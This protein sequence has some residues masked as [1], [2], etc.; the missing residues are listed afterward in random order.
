MTISRKQVLLLVTMTAWMIASIKIIT[1]I[2]LSPLNIHNLYNDNEVTISCDIHPSVTLSVGIPTLRRTSVG[3]QYLWETVRGFVSLS[4]V[5]NFKLELLIFDFTDPIQSGLLSSD[6]KLSDGKYLSSVGK[7]FIKVLVF[8]PGKNRTNHL[9]KNWSP[10]PGIWR[11]INR[12]E[13]K[14]NEDMLHM[15][16]QLRSKACPSQFPNQTAKCGNKH[17]VMLT[18]DDFVPCPRRFSQEIPQ[19]LLS[20]VVSGRNI[21]G[22]RVSSGGSGILIPCTSLENV[23]DSFERMI[24]RGPADSLL[25]FILTYQPLFKYSGLG[26]PI[27]TLHEQKQPYLVYKHSVMQHIGVRRTR[28]GEYPTN[29][30]TN[31]GTYVPGCSSTSLESVGIL[32][33]ETFDLTCLK[34]GSL[35]SPCEKAPAVLTT[36]ISEHYERRYDTKYWHPWITLNT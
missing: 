8:H 14:H 16:R 7:L 5:R 31:F 17:W 6:G 1:Y 15:M 3:F 22:I 4:R 30:P 27:V 2:Y 18:E 33:A 32:I 25:S 9:L 10:V 20:S 36:N 34:A 26:E 13:R 12:H 19:L 11:P 24:D 23:A 21:R 35:V 28:G 29:D